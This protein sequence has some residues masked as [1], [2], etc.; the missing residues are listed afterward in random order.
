MYQKAVFLGPGHPG[1]W[2][3]GCH[4]PDPGG[5]PHS[6]TQSSM[7]KKG[8]PSWQRAL[9]RGTLSPVSPRWISTTASYTTD[10]PPDYHS[11][12]SIVFRAGLGFVWGGADKGEDVKRP[13]PS[14]VHSS[15]TQEHDFSLRLWLP[16][17]H[18]M[19]LTKCFPLVDTSSNNSLKINASERFQ[20]TNF[21]VRGYRDT[22]PETVLWG[23]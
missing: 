20:F 11:M 15:T 12:P 9:R 21:E 13:G 2:G 23:G 5:P 10:L 7:P 16:G 4:A 6:P 19:G 22:S 8:R 1:P 14:T 17:K 3:V 18:Q